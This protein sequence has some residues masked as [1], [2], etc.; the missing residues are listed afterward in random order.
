MRAIAAMM[1]SMILNGSTTAAVLIL[2]AMLADRAVFSTAGDMIV[3]LLLATAGAFVSYAALCG[4]AAWDAHAELQR[5]RKRARDMAAKAV[6]V[7]A[8]S[9]NEA[10]DVVNLADHRREP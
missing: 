1:V 6:S 10:R 7:G 5:R 2:R 8:M 3:L 9:P 4:G